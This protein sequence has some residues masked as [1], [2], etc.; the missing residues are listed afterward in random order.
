L[1]RLCKEVKKSVGRPR[2]S[3]RKAKTPR[4]ARVLFARRAGFTAGKALAQLKMRQSARHA[5][6]DTDE[7]EANTGRLAEL[8]RQFLEDCG[9]DWRVG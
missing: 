7:A 6:E 1:V 9:G 4:K 2:G 3:S 5:A 8:G